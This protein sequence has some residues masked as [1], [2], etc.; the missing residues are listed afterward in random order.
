M[1]G[2]AAARRDAS[3]APRDRTVVGV[4][5]VLAAIALAPLLIFENPPFTDHPNHL[6]RLHVLVADGESPL[7]RVYEPAWALIPNIAL[8][9]FVVAVHPWLTPEAALQWAAVG[10]LGGLLLGVALL[11][12]RL[13][14]A[15]DPL[16]CCRSA[17]E[18]DCNAHGVSSIGV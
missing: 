2:S 16:G 6:A 10:A 3:T 14:G 7:A 1:S 8:D 17:V 11:Q 12:R 9:A 5:L 4:Y 15:V 13:F 18:D